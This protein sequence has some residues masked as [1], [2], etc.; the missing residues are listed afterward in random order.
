M[1]D[2]LSSAR[3]SAFLAGFGGH[4]ENS[5]ELPDGATIFDEHLAGVSGL[6]PELRDAVKQATDD[7]SAEGVSVTVTSGWRSAE[8][9]G[10]LLDGAIADYGS[11]E[12]AARWVASAEKSAHVKGGAVDLGGMD[13]YIWLGD[14][15]R[16]S[17]YGLCQTY[18]NEPWHF[19]FNPD[20]VTEGCPEPYWDPTFDPALAG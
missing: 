12:E 8:L 6:L 5:G 17:R 18:A 15:G 16:A 7:A 11:R 19:Q 4:N 13:A 10:E 9:Q 1:S 3:P 2:A 20:A 14:Q